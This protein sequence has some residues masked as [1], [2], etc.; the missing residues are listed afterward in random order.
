MNSAAG[1]FL[2]FLIAIAIQIFLKPKKR[3]N[4]KKNKREKMNKKN[5]TITIK[6]IGV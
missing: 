3:K 6:A 2:L 1:V 4:Y 5:T